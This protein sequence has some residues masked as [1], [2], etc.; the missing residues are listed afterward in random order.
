V[1]RGR[2]IGRESLA[3]A[4][5][6]MAT[7]MLALVSTVSPAVKLAAGSTAL[8]LGGST[9][10][11][12]DGYYINTVKRLRIGQ[13]LHRGNGRQRDTLTGARPSASS[14]SEPFRLHKEMGSVHTK[15][16]ASS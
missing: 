6:L 11:T 3:F 7:V 2:H 9:V 5:V 8:I 14:G 4:L 13:W 1:E 15:M 12:P 16:A 10:P